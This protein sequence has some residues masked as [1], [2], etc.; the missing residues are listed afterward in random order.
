M[1][2][3]HALIRFFFSFKSLILIGLTK[4]K[5]I[6][7]DDLNWLDN[8]D[9][10]FPYELDCVYNEISSINLAEVG[11]H[12]ASL[13]DTNSWQNL[14]YARVDCNQEIFKWSALKL[15]YT[16][17]LQQECDKNTTKT[18]GFRL[19]AKCLITKKF[20]LAN[21]FKANRFILETRRDIYPIPYAIY[22]KYICI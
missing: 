6:C 18:P 12:F 1:L 8:T 3:N 17:T 7:V 11:I 4:E 5:Y 2:R 14:D 19:G 9:N 22:I 16:F 10:T 13:V 20:L 15:N 21:I